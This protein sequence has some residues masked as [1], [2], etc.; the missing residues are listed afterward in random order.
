MLLNFLSR[1]GDVFKFLITKLQKY[2]APPHVMSLTE[3]AMISINW[4]LWYQE[5]IP[6]GHMSPFD[7]I[8]LSQSYQNLDLLAS[9]GP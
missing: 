7:F 3:Q 4:F 6:A 5:K 1:L 8:G 9:A 2:W